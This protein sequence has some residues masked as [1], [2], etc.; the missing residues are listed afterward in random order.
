MTEPEYKKVLRS[1][2]VGGIYA[3]LISCIFLGW[4][5]L[6]LAA[7]VFVGSAFLSSCIETYSRRKTR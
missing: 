7:G 5:G 3:G 4:W 1:I 2:A 6:A